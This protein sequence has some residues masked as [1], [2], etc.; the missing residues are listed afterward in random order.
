MYTSHCASHCW[1]STLDACLF[2]NSV[3]QL[4]CPLQACFMCFLC[5]F[6]C[7]IHCDVVLLFL[8]W[9]ALP[10]QFSDL[11]SSFSTIGL[12]N[13]HIS[14]L[15]IVSC[16]RVWCLSLMPCSPS[17]LLFWSLSTLQ[18]GSNSLLQRL[19]GGVTMQ[20]CVVK[21]FGQLSCRKKMLPSDGLDPYSAL[22]TGQRYVCVNCWESWKVV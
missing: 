10:L 1:M 15:W 21:Y 22:I 8:W 17:Y 19:K 4:H 7:W 11:K 9:H 13:H 14:F 20:R 16:W 2:S 5:T 18:E 12:V 3:T 6:L